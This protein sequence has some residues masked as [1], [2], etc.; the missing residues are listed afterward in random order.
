MAMCIDEAGKERDFTEVDRFVFRIS[1]CVG[2]TPDPND[3]AGGNFNGAIL[4][5]R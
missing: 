4:Y 5:G 3:F 2:P 1:R